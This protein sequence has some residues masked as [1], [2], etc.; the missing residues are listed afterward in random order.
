[1]SALALLSIWTFDGTVQIDTVGADNGEGRELISLGDLR[2]A[3]TSTTAMILEND[4][5][6]YG[7]LRTHDLDAP[8][9]NFADEIVLVIWYE[10]DTCGV[11]VGDWE[12]WDLGDR[13]HIDVSFLDAGQPC[14]DP[15]QS[16][17]AVALE[18]RDLPPTWTRAVQT[19]I[20]A[21]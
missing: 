3:P 10:S 9:V 7:L 15:G 21:I 17:L 8:P 19:R 11:D 16:V 13:W 6:W 2:G 14:S 5:S 20:A 18:R 12:V 4:G 1:M